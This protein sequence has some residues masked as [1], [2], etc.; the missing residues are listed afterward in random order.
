M[1]INRPKK[2]SFVTSDKDHGS[3]LNGL[4]CVILL[5][6]FLINFFEMISSSRMAI[7]YKRKTFLLTFLFLSIFIIESAQSESYELSNIHTVDER[8]EIH[9]Y[10]E[11]S[12]EGLP[13]D[14]YL[15]LVQ[16]ITRFEFT[17]LPENKARDL[18]E[19]LTRDS[20]A[21]MKVPGGL[22]SRR[23]IYIQTLLKKMKIISGKILIKCPANNGRLRLQDQISR[24]YITYTNF[25]DTNIVVINTGTTQEFRVMD[26]QF[27]D[28]PVSLHEYL[29]QIEASQK[30]RPAKRRGNSSGLCYWSIST[31]SLTY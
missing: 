18:F 17:L 15:Q 26:L 13:P 1:N 20:K 25:H 5:L 9:N 21:R 14:H 22:C 12:D 10:V 8:E 2:R 19:E 6:A 16:M 27:Q 7:R 29:T 23:R 30:I 11:V 31:N 28:T 3:K 4:S 24:R